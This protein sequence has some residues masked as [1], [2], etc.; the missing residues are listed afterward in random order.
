MDL[1]LLLKL[2]PH[3]SF[4]KKQTNVEVLIFH[5]SWSSGV[6]NS[7]E[8]AVKVFSRISTG[9]WSVTSYQLPFTSYQLPVTSYQSPVTSYQLALSTPGIIY[10]NR[11]PKSLKE[12]KFTRMHN[13]VLSHFASMQDGHKAVDGHA[14]HPRYQGREDTGPACHSVTTGEGGPATQETGDTLESCQGY[15]HLWGSTQYNIGIIDFFMKVMRTKTD[16]RK[17][18]ILA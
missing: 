3:H 7:S 11:R 12:G 14:G 15:I 2:E 10:L 17:W 6:G 13:F 1:P 9:G 5:S 4:E 18:V 8:L 16:I